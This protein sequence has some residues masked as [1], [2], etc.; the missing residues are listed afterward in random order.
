MEEESSDWIS[1]EEEKQEEESVEEEVE[2]IGEEDRELER[3]EQVDYEEEDVSY[4]YDPPT[5]RAKVLTDRISELPDSIIIHILS[6]IPT[7]DAIKTSALSKRWCHTWAS[8]S[9]LIYIYD[10]RSLKKFTK[11]VDE[12]LILHRS[13]KIH[14][15]ILRSK[16][17]LFMKSS[18]SLW[19]RAAV[20]KQV[21]ELIIK[22]ERRIH[23]PYSL[24]QSL[25]LCDSLT[26]LSVS[27]CRVDPVYS[28]L[29]W[30]LL[31]HLTLTCAQ[32]E[33][34]VIQKV[35]TGSPF[36][37][38]LKLKNCSWFG[39]IDI[40][41]ERLRRL[42]I[43]GYGSNDQIPGS[44]W[45]DIYAPN[46]QSLEIL[47]FVGEKKCRLKNV[48]SLI[49]A[50]LTFDM[51]SWD[52][53]ESEDDNYGDDDDYKTKVE[54]LQ[55]MVRDIMEKVRHVQSLTLGNWIV[56]VLSTC[57]LM[58]LPSSI[59]MRKHLLLEIDLS[60]KELPGIATLFRTSPILER[61]VI[62]VSR[63]RSYAQIG[64][65]EE[66][67]LY[68]VAN[69]WTTKDMVSQCLKVV[70]IIGFSELVIELSQFLLR[71]AKALEKMVFNKG[72]GSYNRWQLYFGEEDFFEVIQKLLSFPR[73][74][75]K[76][77]ILLL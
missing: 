33:D 5:K 35:L 19:I 9:T 11:F 53:Y 15:F 58:H 25:Y 49:H 34:G 1:S 32:L 59:S 36:L 73:S 48:S 23:S 26:K 69:Y 51:R 12:T 72:K 57:E 64:Y 71:N 22:F 29:N 70:E 21:E 8:T 10:R 42:V 16:Y 27:Y 65:F 56:Q 30:R 66:L 18:V 37:E 68:D 47:D 55:N 3:E 76:A 50:N 74:S 6:L 63:S 62:D 14:K 77:Q 52:A 39:R 38:S 43:N 67:Y 54:D 40:H 60:R 7:R 28:L 61:L 4:N 31:K 20:I 44:G 13:S 2:D 75:P 46:V 41:S 45:L 24:P 17:E